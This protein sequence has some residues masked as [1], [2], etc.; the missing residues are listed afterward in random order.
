MDRIL[1]TGVAGFLGSNLAQTLLQD[2]KNIIYGIDNF[3]SSS[4]S[5]LYPMLKNS[6]FEF[7][8]H[9]LKEDI[10]LDVDCIYHLAGNGDFKNYKNDKYNFILDSIETTKNIIEFAQNKG[11]KLILTTQYHDYQ[12]KNGDM[13]K[14]FDY[15]KLIE[16]LTLE[17]IDKNKL[18]AVFARLDNTYGQ[19]MIKNDNRF[20]PKTIVNAIQNIDIELEY[21]DSYYFTYV[22]D[23][24]AILIKIMNNYQNESIIDVFNQN[25]YLKSD[26]AKLIIAYSKSSSKLI[27]K[28]NETYTPNYNNNNPN[29]FKCETKVIDGIFDTINWF[30]L[31]Y[32]S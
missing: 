17:L 24:V 3:S 15:L 22:Q 5:N 13:F 20:I 2:E 19:N 10:S 9:N 21:D 26:I 11:A 12:E 14:Y 18:N 25:L 4:M 31:M 8:E 29:D 16:S 6:R 1:I 27:L 23:V 28:S 30:K 7:I 32:F